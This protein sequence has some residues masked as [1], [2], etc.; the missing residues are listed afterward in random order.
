MCG[1]CHAW[2]KNRDKPETYVILSYTKDQERRPFGEFYKRTSV[3]TVEEIL[4]F[5]AEQLTVLH[6]QVLQK[7]LHALDLS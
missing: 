4:T 2:E 6:A 1:T 5:P 7:A 3:P